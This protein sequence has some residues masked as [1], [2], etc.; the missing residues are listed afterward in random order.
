MTVLK[1]L[2]LVER[3]LAVHG[4]KEMLRFQRQSAFHPIRNP[5]SYTHAP[6]PQAY[7]RQVF[8]PLDTSRTLPSE[9]CH[10]NVGPSI[11]TEI[12]MGTYRYI[13]GGH[14]RQIHTELTIKVGM[15]GNIL[16]PI[17][18]ILFIIKQQL[19]LDKPR[20]THLDVIESAYVS[21][22]PEI[23]TVYGRF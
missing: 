12:R 8:G 7:M 22:S 3:V 4:I 19:G 11:D 9:Q 10:G 1:K 6:S 5:V 16:C 21:A 20:V 14:D 17:R 13:E 23:G 2:M 18:T 15:R